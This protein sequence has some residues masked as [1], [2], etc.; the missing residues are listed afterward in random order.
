MKTL[1]TGGTGY[2]G[3][4]TTVELILEGHE[5]V[6]LDDL[7]NSKASVVDRIGEITGVAPELIVG[8][9]RDRSLLDQVMGSQDFDAVMHFAALKAVGESVREPLKYW[10][11][12]VA[13][14]LRLIE[15]MVE[16]GIERVVFS[17]SATVYGEPD[18]VPVSEAD[19]VRPPSN[20][21]G[22]TKLV[23]E[24]MLTDTSVANPEWAIALLRYFNPIGAH[25]SGLIGEDPND[26]PNNLMPYV[27]Q[28]ASERLPELRVFGDD[29]PTRDGTG[30][31][32]YIHVVDLAKGHTAALAKLA[33]GP[34]RWVYNLGTGRGTTVLELVDAFEE[35]SGVNVPYRI[36]GRR[37]GDVAE[38]WADPSLAERELGWKATYGIEQMCV[39]TWRWQQYATGLSD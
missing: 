1:V 35:A 23:I 18:S 2:I 26:E 31:R 17:S 7:S 25:A 20:P 9:V 19:P 34:G 10:D 39:D 5:V 28:V 22:W 4:H 14:S 3:S 21:Y 8:D 27:A 11:V 6:I 16:H 37:A 33:E 32:D 24:Q 29:Y 13:G 12:N 38:L 36:V 15:A 30:V